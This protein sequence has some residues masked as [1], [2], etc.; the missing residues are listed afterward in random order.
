MFGQGLVVVV[1]VCFV[2]MRLCQKMKNEKLTTAGANMGTCGFPKRTKP[3]FGQWM[4]PGFQLKLKQPGFCQ[5]PEKAG[6]SF[7]FRWELGQF[8]D[9]D[10][11][12]VVTKKHGT[13]G[14]QG[15]G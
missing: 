7:V 14:T 1:V 8:S 3:G 5:V 11:L 4:Q 13:P 12:I 2:P 15:F 10:G 6:F 9:G